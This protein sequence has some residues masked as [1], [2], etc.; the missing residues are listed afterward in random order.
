[1]FIK[2]LFLAL[3]F[4]SFTLA[5]VVKVACIGDSNTVR[6]HYPRELQRLLGNSYKVKQFAVSG[7][8]LLSGTINPKG[9]LRGYM[10]LAKYKEAL[11]YNPD[12][13]IIMLG[14]NDSM[15]WDDKA[16]DAKFPGTLKEEFTTNMKKMTEELK[17]ANPTVKVFIVKPLPVFPSKSRPAIRKTSIERKQVLESV[18]YDHIEAIAKDL[19]L[20]LIDVYSPMKNDIHLTQDGVHY[21]KAGYHKMA[22]IIAEGIKK[23]EMDVDEHNDDYKKKNIDAYNENL[24]QVFSCGDSIS[25]GYAPYLKESLRHSFS[26]MHRID[27]IK[28][29][30]LKVNYRGPIP[31]LIETTRKA[32][33]SKQF[34]PKYLLLNSGLHDAKRG[35]SLDGYRESL[36]I[37][38]GLAKKHK[39]ELVWITTTK[40]A[41]KDNKAPVID[42]YNKLAK[43]LVSEAGFNFIDLGGFTENL[44]LNN[45]PGAVMSADKVHFTPRGYKL[46]G[47]FLATKLQEII[48][49]QSLK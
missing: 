31:S 46:Q 13:A 33:E 23:S 42:S 40:T 27:A 3:G 29:F 2:L 17:E 43:R 35:R 37:I 14:T 10:E 49:A 4:L 18:L 20:P 16:R 41:K 36:M 28:K 38:I 8:T 32:L 7:S 9:Q 15:Y 45:R 19:K 30:K 11:A 34:N 26:V 44:I 48:K 39:K 12:I 1:M 5:K 47:E 22:S 24:P 25:A 6:H 21:L